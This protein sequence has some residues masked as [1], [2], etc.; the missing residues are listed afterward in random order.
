MLFV[1]VYV[2][3]TS[4]LKNERC[5]FIHTIATNVQT[6]SKIPELLNWYRTWYR[7]KNHVC[8][9]M[10]RKACVLRLYVTLKKLAEL[11]EIL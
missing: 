4:G 5:T 11:L 9:A 7:T 10:T 2:F 6:S 8:L 1:N 3:T